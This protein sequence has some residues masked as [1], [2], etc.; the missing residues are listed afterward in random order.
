MTHHPGEELMQHTSQPPENT[1]GGEVLSLPLSTE[2]PLKAQILAGRGLA[3]E[4][5]PGGHQR[6]P[7]ERLVGLLRLPHV[8]NAESIVA[9]RYPVEHRTGMAPAGA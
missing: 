6:L 8:G 4:P 1:L 9:S 5:H 3:A 2:S 7:L